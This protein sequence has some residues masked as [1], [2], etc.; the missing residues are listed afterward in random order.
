MFRKAFTFWRGPG[1]SQ[2]DAAIR[3]MAEEA[4]T[5]ILQFHIL[6][7]GVITGP[8]YPPHSEETKT[9]GQKVA[10]LQLRSSLRGSR[11][12]CVSKCGGGVVLPVRQRFGK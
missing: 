12:I 6:L 2:K 5:T 10:L 11:V 9:A 3:E 7:P 8:L 1:R 4:T